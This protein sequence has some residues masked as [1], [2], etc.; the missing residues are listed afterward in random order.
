MLFLSSS[1][2]NSRTFEVS[3]K[4]V[5]F[6]CRTLFTN[7]VIPFSLCIS[8]VSIRCT[9]AK[10]KV[11]VDGTISLQID[12]NNTHIRGD[13]GKSIVINYKEAGV[14]NKLVLKI[15]GAIN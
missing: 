3:L 12:Y 7:A 10:S 4:L 13:F 8:F 14:K 2:L 1:P 6:S 11:N 9:F 15:K 5:L